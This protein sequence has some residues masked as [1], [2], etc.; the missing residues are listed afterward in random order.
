MSTLF[1]DIV[2]LPPV[3]LGECL[4]TV[5]ESVHLQW[6]GDI[7]AWRL[8]ASGGQCSIESSPNAEYSSIRPILRYYE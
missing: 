2:M 6:R 1:T 7:V 4:F 8:K 5:L 3:L